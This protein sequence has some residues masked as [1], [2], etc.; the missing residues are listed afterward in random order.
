MPAA[1]R[2]ISESVDGTSIPGTVSLRG[3]RRPGQRVDPIECPAHAPVR[4]RHVGFEP[5]PEQGAATREPLQTAGHD[6]ARPLQHVEVEVL[7]PVHPGQRHAR[8][9]PRGNGIGNGVDRHVEVAE[10]VDPAPDVPAAVAPR[11]ARVP[12]GRDRD[13]AARTSELERELLSGRSCADDEHAAVRQ[14]V[15]CDVAARVQRE[16]SG[17][18]GAGGVRKQGQVAV[19]GRD[20]DVPRA[21]CSTAGRDAKALGRPLDAHDGDSFRHGGGEGRRVVLQSRHEAVARRVRVRVSGDRLA[22]ERA[23]PRRGQERERLP[24]LRPP[25]LP[26]A[27]ALE[28]DVAPAGV[29]ELAAQREAG[30]AAADDHRLRHV[31]AAHRSVTSFPRPTSARRSYA[32]LAPSGCMN[33]PARTSR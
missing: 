11:Q 15:G 26:D 22:G 13:R 31:V 30:L 21:P 33:A 6:D 16:S 18:N 5:A 23:R 8:S 17:R 29:R 12:A 14:A 7:S 32:R 10:L 4:V 19:T 27:T 2:S 1:R 9:T 3:A 20:D 28:D 25:P 24:S